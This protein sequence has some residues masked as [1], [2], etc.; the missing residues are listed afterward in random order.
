MTVKSPHVLAVEV[1]ILESVSRPNDAVFAPMADV[2]IRDAGGGLKIVSG[3][4]DLKNEYGLFS[5][6]GYMAQVGTESQS[7]KAFAISV[8]IVN[9]A[10]G[11]KI[12]S[13]LTP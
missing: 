9:Q 12:K 10:T 5:R 8:D 4:V 13:I 6:V 3:W 1:V 11:S 2:M 7:G